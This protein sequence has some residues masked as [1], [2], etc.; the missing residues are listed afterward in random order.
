MLDREGTYLWSK[1]EKGVFA[2]C[3]VVAADS[4]L[5]LLRQAHLKKTA[6]S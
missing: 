3:L 1:R 6:L 2:G 4:L 5:L